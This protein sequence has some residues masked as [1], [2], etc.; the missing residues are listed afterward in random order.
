MDGRKE[1]K[2]NTDVDGKNDKSKKGEVP[3]F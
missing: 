2:E 3:V 1:T